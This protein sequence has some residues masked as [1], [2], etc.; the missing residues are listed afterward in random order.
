MGY[1]GYTVG[2]QHIG[3]RV[4]VSKKSHKKVKS[5]LANLVKGRRG[6][7][8]I[9][10]VIAL[11]GVVC[12]VL[13]RAATPYVSIEPENGTATSPAAAFSDTTAS[14]GRA[15]KFG[16]ASGCGGVSDKLV[17]A[18]GA[19]LGAW[20]NDHGTASTL[21]AQTDEHEARIGRKV[22]VVRWYHGAGSTSLTSDEKYYI[23]RDN[24][25]LLMNWKPA[26]PWANGSG[27]NATVNA[28]IDAMADSI[29][30]VAPKKIMLNVYHEPE[31]DVKS[32][33]PSCPSNFSYAGS[34]GT[35]AEYVAMWKNTRARFDAKGVNNVVWAVNYM[36]YPKYD[37]MVKDLWPGNNL[38]D[39]V[40]YDPYP[41]GSETWD[42]GFGRFYNWLDANS[43]A[44]HAF[45]SK[46]YGIGEWGTWHSDAT[47][48]RQFYI[49]GKAALAAGKFP[50]IK[51]YAIFD[52]IG[53][54]DSSVDYGPGVKDSGAHG[55][56][57]PQELA[58]YKSFVQAPKLYQQP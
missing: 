28:Q 53:V 58:N 54:Q 27:S 17:P 55:S 51:L 34:Q 40:L 19:W 44:T 15:L 45:S 4:P 33:A 56:P 14:G 36:S 57:D 30:S 2:K 25:Y 16:A 52:A 12:M 42:T 21:R 49:D 48:S 6:K 38:V 23:N 43:D 35:P 50:K 18:C 37:C 41:A 1:I 8:L 22:N 20:S 5:R 3:I 46:I 9:I 32:G 39:W 31:N 11:V 29:K 47:R 13:A 7:Y 24:T 10:F 26:Q